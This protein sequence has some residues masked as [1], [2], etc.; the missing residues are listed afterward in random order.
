MP[1]LTAIPIVDQHAHNLL[2]PEQLKTFAYPAAFTEAYEPEVVDRHVPETLFFRRSLR[3]IA[4]VLGCD[5]DLPAVL[6]ARQRLGFEEVA[7]RAFEAGN[8]EALLLDDGFV[9]DQILPTAWHT[10]FVPV[11]RL[12]RIE[13][14]AENLIRETDTWADFQEAFRTTLQNLPPDVVGLKSIAAYRTGL[15]IE[16]PGP[17]TAAICF[18]NLRRQAEAGDP[19]R[20][21]CKPLNDWVVWITLE[22]AARQGIPVQFHTGFGDPDLDLRWANPVHMRPLF[23]NPS[24][25]QMPI[26]LLHASYPF[27]REA[28]YL[29][30]VYPNVY[31]DLGLAI[32][33]LSVAGMRFAVQAFLEL[34]PLSKIIFSTDAHLIAELFYLGARWG[35]RVLAGAL[36]E[37]VRNGDLT[38]REAEMAAEL[39]L[40]RNAIKLYGLPE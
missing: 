19:I 27:T 16:A 40:R 7:R 25:Q 33:F 24:F 28:G 30:A 39:I 35:R 8:F 3:E 9:P 20:L 14:L 6:A 21:E 29:A 5:A 32:P 36:E 31:V 23:E 11:F 22:E 18:R 26:V 38:A 2:R 13:F 12:L 17:E 34:T 37:A 4:A 1:D 15:A 10:R